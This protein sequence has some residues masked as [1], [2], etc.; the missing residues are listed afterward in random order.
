MLAKPVALAAPVSI[1][2][3]VGSPCVIS[4]CVT[5]CV[6][7]PCEQVEADFEPDVD[8]GLEKLDFSAFVSDGHVSWW[9]VTSR[10]Q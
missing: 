3:L 1:V 5:P 8:G 6:A 2:S 7:S 9:A 4:P 10:Y